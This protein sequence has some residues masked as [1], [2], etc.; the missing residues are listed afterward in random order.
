[1]HLLHVLL[2][3]T[4]R[5]CRALLAQWAGDATLLVNIDVVGTEKL[6]VAAVEVRLQVLV[7]V[8]HVVDLSP[9]SFT[10]G[11]IE[12]AHGAGKIGDLRAGVR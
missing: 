4:A 2:E 6:L 10:D 3:T 7:E 8:R 5:R 12:R 11:I 1:M 9:K